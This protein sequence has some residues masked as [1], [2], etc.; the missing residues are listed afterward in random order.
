M[1]NKIKK[2]NMFDLTKLAISTEKQP[3][4]KPSYEKKITLEEQ[5]KLLKDYIELSKDKW[6]NINVGDHI[7]YLRKD[8]SFRRGGFFKSSWVVQQGKNEG[9]TFIQLSS[10]LYNGKT[11]AVIDA[12]L[13]KIYIKNNKQNL[14][15]NITKNE[16]IEYLNKSVEQLKIDMLKCM[17]EQ[18][19]IIN[20]IKKLH[21]IHSHKKS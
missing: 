18:K 21:G 14:S 11:W 6:S 13:D 10:S 9:K 15:T 8:G 5:T 1:D 19:R 4:I 7:R 20:L 12:D 16:S 2:E 3:E 17:N